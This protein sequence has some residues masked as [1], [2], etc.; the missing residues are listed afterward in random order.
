MS[1]AV[2]RTVAHLFLA[3]V[4]AVCV[5]GNAQSPILLRDVTEGSG[6]QFRHTDG[7]SGQRY[8]VETVTSGLASF[9]FDGD[10]RIDLYFPNGAALGSSANEQGATN[11]LYRN[12][13]DGRYTDVS[14]ASGTDDGQ[15]GLGVAIGDYDNDGFADIYV[16]N[17]GH[18][19]LYRNNGDGTYSDVTRRAGVA[20]QNHKVGAGVCFLD[21]E[22]DGDLD[23]YCANYVR[24]TPAT[25]VATVVD[26]HPQYTGPKDYQPDPDV[27]YRNNGDGTFTDIS[28]ES[29]IAAHQGTG[30]GIVCCD[31]DNDGDTDIFV[32]N[33]VRGNFLF[34]NDGRGHF[35]EVGLST[36][37]A[38]SMDGMELGSMGVDC[39]DYDNDGWLDLYQT[40]YS[41]ELPGLYHNTTLGFFEDVTRAS[42]AGTTVF[43]YVNWGIGFVDLDNDGNRDL[44]VANGHLQDNVHLY[45]DTTSYRVRNTVY[46]N[47]GGGKFR[48]VSDQ[49]G[50][51]LAVS[52]SSRGAVFDDLDN[53]G[54]TDVVILNSRTVPTV[55]RNESDNSNQWLDIRLHGRIASRDGVGSRVAVT[56]GDLTQVAEVHSGRGYQSHFGSRLHF[57]LGKRQ[58][59][60]RLEI[61]WLGGGR[62]VLTDVATNQILHV[63]ETR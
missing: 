17:F 42:G 5:R 30:M 63:V 58:R 6:I 8:I 13:G 49:C 1:R 33:D 46:R 7:S 3:A 39:A 22:G 29:G 11:A 55:L 38:Y 4:L 31:Y 47:V 16:S 60:D 43:P 48:D 25:H 50:D 34:E 26:G 32:L 18:N 51:G 21:I 24:F 23:L 40:S 10:E 53:D 52:E 61:Q 57:G 41:G 36:G 12:M 56:A 35:R 45:D 15:F 37:V 9:D 20:C 62:Q 14:R 27:L 19:V 54:R 2:I 44:F 59:V 28:A